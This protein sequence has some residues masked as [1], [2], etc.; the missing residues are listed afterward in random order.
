M[1]N[2]N[3]SFLFVLHMFPC[4]MTGQDHQKKHLRNWGTVNSALGF[5]YSELVGKSELY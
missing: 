1:I 5:S 4:I 2:H 3:L